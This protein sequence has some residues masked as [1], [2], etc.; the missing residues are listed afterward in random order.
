VLWFLDEIDRARALVEE[1][2]QLW[3]EADDQE[4]VAWALNRLGT[5]AE[6]GGDVARNWFEQS[7]AVY[8][9][10]GSDG[11]AGV[12]NNLGLWAHR[13]G[14]LARARALLEEAVA[15]Q[16]RSDENQPW[17]GTFI[18]LAHI[19]RHEGNNAEARALLLET[20]DICRGQGNRRLIVEGLEG[21]A[22][23]AM[24]EHQWDRAAR[25]F[26]AAERLREEI[27]WRK[28]YSDTAHP[29]DALRATMGEA[30]FIGEWEAGRA[31]PWRQA[32]Q[33]TLPEGKL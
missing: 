11:A 3:R 20:L 25:W 2:L 8:R 33:Q 26:G 18:H 23:V 10:I 5:L 17:P 6:E 21:L 31:V 13:R 24:T 9:R 29:L 12:L 19:A 16:R 27:Q 1:S 22:L 30:A 14:D 28:R 15:I 32:V 4:G 7:L